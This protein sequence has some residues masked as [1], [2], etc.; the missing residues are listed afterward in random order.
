M[1][2]QE[3]VKAIRKMPTPEPPDDTVLSGEPSPG[4]ALASLPAGAPAVPPARHKTSSQMILARTLL[5]RL[6]NLQKDLAA[7]NEPMLSM[8]AGNLAQELEISL[9]NTEETS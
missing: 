9:D 4:P 7:V 1:W 2:F 6:R 8:R 5:H 3:L